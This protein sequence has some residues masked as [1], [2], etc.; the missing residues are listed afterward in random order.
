VKSGLILGEVELNPQTRVLSAFSAARGGP[1]L[2]PGVLVFLKLLELR[3]ARRESFVGF[4]DMG[5]CR[6]LCEIDSDG[7]ASRERHRQLAPG[8]PSLIPGGLFTDTR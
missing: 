5:P 7:I 4:L 8:N 3:L 6:V 1:R 2:L